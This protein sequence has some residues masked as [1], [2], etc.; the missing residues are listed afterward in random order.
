MVRAAEFEGYLATSAAAG[1]GGLSDEVL[2]RLFDQFLDERLLRRLAVERGV[3]EAGATPREAVVAL[4]EKE[5]VL[6][7]PI[8]D[9]DIAAYYGAH[10]AD[11]RRPERL[12]LRQILTADR[13]TAE[14]ARAEVLA[15][16]RFAAVAR[17]LS[18]DAHARRGGFQG[19]FA[20]ED[21][22]PAFADLLFGLPPGAVSPVLDAPSGYH[23]FQVVA[24][25]PEHEL[26]IAEAEVEIRAALERERGDRTLAALAAEARR[27]YTLAIHAPNLPFE[28]QP[29]VASPGQPS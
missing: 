11:F 22:P 8:A 15:G 26:A 29:A 23:V 12:R 28:Y 27:R 17:R 24:H 1:S 9:A 2:S 18:R 6:G 5:R 21:L 10:R 16:A 19:E 14:R 13:A 7:G 25:L 4:L 20:R 3:V